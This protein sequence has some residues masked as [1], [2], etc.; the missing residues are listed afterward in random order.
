MVVRLILN[1]L[2]S[3]ILTKIIIKKI[4][5]NAIESELSLNIEMFGRRK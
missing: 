4:D 1:F 2:F 3:K 5:D